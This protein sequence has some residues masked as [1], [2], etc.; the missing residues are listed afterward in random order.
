MRCQNIWTLQKFFIMMQKKHILIWT[1]E[2]CI[3]HKV[4][5]NY[6]SLSLQ[7]QLCSNFS[8]KVELQLRRD[9]RYNSEI[10]YL[11]SQQKHMLSPLIRTVSGTE[12]GL[13]IRRSNRDNLG[14]IF[15]ISSIKHIL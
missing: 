11:I 2:F 14:I 3:H 6:D 15:S 9:N 5:D 4:L 10:T 12:S 13:Q 8:I 1:C 7:L